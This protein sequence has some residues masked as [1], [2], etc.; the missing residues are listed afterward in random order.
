MLIYQ[1]LSLIKERF[2]QTLIDIAKY[3]QSPLK[4]NPSGMPSPSAYVEWRALR[5]QLDPFRKSRT[6]NVDII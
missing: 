3:V 2:W 5:V 1:T 4:A 6:L